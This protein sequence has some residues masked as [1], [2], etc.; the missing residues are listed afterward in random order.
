MDG[1]CQMPCIFYWRICGFCVF[2][3]FTS[4]VVFASLLEVGFEPVA[5]EP[6]CHDW[7]RDSGWQRDPEAAPED[8][9]GGR[10]VRPWSQTRTS[11][12]PTETNSICKRCS[13]PPRE[14]RWSNAVRSFALW[15]SGDL[16]D[17]I[18]REQGGDES[19]T[20]SAVRR[21][22]WFGFEVPIRFD[23]QGAERLQ[24]RHRIFVRRTQA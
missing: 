16:N 21:N 14:P 19:R 23:A 5:S 20:R 24:N 12:H 17:S 6:W 10:H 22:A 13:C 1:R 11:A 7:H 15:P 3:K 4:G 9:R 18:R 2:K 8:T